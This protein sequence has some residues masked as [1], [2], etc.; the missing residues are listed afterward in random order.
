MVRNVQYSSVASS[1]LGGILLQY[2]P[3]IYLLEN[4]KINYTLDHTKILIKRYTRPTKNVSSMVPGIHSTNLS[5]L[6]LN[7]ITIPFDLIIEDFW[8]HKSI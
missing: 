1:V 3:L 4:I 2:Y 6:N 7:K 8:A 5:K